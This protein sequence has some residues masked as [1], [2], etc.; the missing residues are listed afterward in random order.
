MTYYSHIHLKRK[1]MKASGS[2]YIKKNY[3]VNVSA[4]CEMSVSIY[5]LLQGEYNFP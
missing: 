3:H 4:L 2:I 5:C 1:T